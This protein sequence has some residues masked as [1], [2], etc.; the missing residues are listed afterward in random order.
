MRQIRLSGLFA[1]WSQCCAVGIRVTDGNLSILSI[2]YHVALIRDAT[3]GL[4]TP[5]LTPH[6]VALRCCVTHSIPS[7]TIGVEGWN[8][9]LKLTQKAAETKPVCRIRGDQMY[10]I[11]PFTHTQTNKQT[12]CHVVVVTHLRICTRGWR[13]FVTWA[14]AYLVLVIASSPRG[15]PQPPTRMAS[16]SKRRRDPTCSL[17]R[18]AENLGVFSGA[19]QLLQLSLK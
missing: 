7:P 4:D 19:V 2:I 3:V 18:P 13:F 10:F 9:G 17:Q 16:K 11:L 1:A 5:D 14:A 6:L 15:V 12:R 8:N